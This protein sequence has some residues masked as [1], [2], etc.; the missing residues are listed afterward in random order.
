MNII[1]HLPL[2]VCA[3][4]AT[5]GG[6]PAQA[7]QLVYQVTGVGT[8]ID[9]TIDEQPALK[10]V[11]VDGFIVGNVLVQRNGISQ[12]HD[13]GFVR[14]LSEGGFIILGTDINLAG[15][16]LFSGTF[17]APTLLAG[18]FPLTGFN[19]RA[20]LYSLQVRAATAAVPEPATWLVLLTGF[21]L[22]GAALRGRPRMRAVE[23][24]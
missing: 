17:A 24:G 20:L 11:E 18:N 23:S 10:S 3:G 4:V 6:L 2:L 21:G 15:P 1:K 13:I 14:G 9:F 5:I 22:L 12:M 19:N 8:T 16:Q 7:S